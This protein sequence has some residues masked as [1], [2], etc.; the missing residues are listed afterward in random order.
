[1]SCP[2]PNLPLWKSFFWLL[3]SPGGVQSGFGVVSRAGWLSRPRHAKPLGAL[4]WHRARH[5][6]FLR[7]G[8]VPVSQEVLR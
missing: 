4:H 5:E 3:P 2:G 1:M 8:P 6:P 7:L